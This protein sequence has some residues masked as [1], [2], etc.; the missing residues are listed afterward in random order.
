MN[1]KSHTNTLSDLSLAQSL[2]MI[3]MNTFLF[4]NH[5][6]VNKLFIKS[7][8]FSQT[9]S[10]RLTKGLRQDVSCALHSNNPSTHTHTHTFT[11]H[12]H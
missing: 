10:E 12:I 11:N 7:Y 8:M 9:Y 3:M 6:I 1:S 5:N 4:T 2:M